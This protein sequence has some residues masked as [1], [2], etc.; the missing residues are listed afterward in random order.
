VG[1]RENNSQSSWPAFYRDP[2]D[3]KRYRPSI[4]TRQVAQIADITLEDCKAVEIA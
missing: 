3:T 4:Q 2:N 1:E